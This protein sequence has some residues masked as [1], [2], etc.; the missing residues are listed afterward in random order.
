MALELKVETSIGITAEKAYVRIDTL[1]GSKNTIIL[2]VKSYFSQ[3]TY[4]GGKEPYESKEYSFTPSVEEGSDNFIRQG[5]K[6]LK[7]LP[8][9]EG[10]VD[11][12]ED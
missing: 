9:F 2:N 11:V 3:E 7:T 4:D 5:Y 12:L 1:F 8:D 6:Y 10:A